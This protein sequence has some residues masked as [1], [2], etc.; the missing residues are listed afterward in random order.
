MPLVDVFICTY[1]EEEAILERT[2]VGALAMDYANYR[3]WVLDDGRRAWLRSCAAAWVAAISRGP[4]MPMPRPATS[5]TPCASFR[6]LTEPPDFISILDADFVPMPQF[7]TR[8]LTLFR[9]GDVGIV[10]TPQH[11]IN[12]D[13]MQSNLSAAQCGPTSS[14]T[15]SMSS[16]PPRMPGAPPSAAAPPP[17][18]ASRL[19][20]DS[21]A[22]PPTP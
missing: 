11:F 16:W 7:L 3:V 2:I 1:N 5:T 4:T 15:S 18:S 14:A 17:S 12:P 9:E 8:A 10:Q 21:A 20:A 22:F 19:C 13:P 6:G